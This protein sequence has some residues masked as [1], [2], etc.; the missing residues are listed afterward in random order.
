MVRSRLTD[1]ESGFGE[2][3]RFFGDL[4]SFWVDPCLVSLGESWAVGISL[5]GSST[6][7]GSAWT[8]VLACFSKGGRGS[9]SGIFGMGKSL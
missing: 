7:G 8:D 9:G 4:V 6:M 1:E 3:E 2:I 5:D